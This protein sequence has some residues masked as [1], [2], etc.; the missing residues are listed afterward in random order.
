MTTTNEVITNEVI[1]DE[2]IINEVTT[3]EVITNEVT[4]NEVTTNELITNIKENFTSINEEINKIKV[5]ITKSEK[6]FNSI[7]GDKLLAQN[8]VNSNLILQINVLKTKHIYINSLVNKIVETFYDE[9]SEL[10]NRTIKILNI[11][12]SLEYKPQNKKFEIL[13][14]IKK[15]RLNESI[16]ISLLNENIDIVFNN[17]PLIKEFIDLFTEFI[18]ETKN[19]SLKD[20]VHNSV[21]EID[22]FYKKEKLL[23]EYNK[24]NEV[25][26]NTIIYFDKVIE[27]TLKDIKQ[28]N[29]IKM[30]I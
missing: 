6:H 3:N 11:L 24:S 26:S 14:K 29:I 25:F 2:V 27:N 21:Y 17:L 15:I 8:V 19:L 28:S 9:I 4:T 10:I 1:T 23:L 30:Y 20:N 12:N 16:S 18:E 5:K 22:I 7:N 13:E